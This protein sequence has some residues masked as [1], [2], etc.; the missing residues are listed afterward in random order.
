MLTLAFAAVVAALHA[1]GPKLRAVPGIAP[2]AGVS[3]AGGLAGAYVFIHVLPEL[4]RGNREV[5]AT[6]GHDLG[7]SAVVDVAVF[8]VALVGFSVF[9]LLQ[10]AAEQTNRERREP[11]GAV[12]VSHLVAFT[13]YNAVV[14]FTLPLR[15]QTSP[16]LAAAFCAILA[17]HLVS[18]DRLLREQFPQRFSVRA[19]PRMVLA[20][21]ALG[22]WLLAGV[23][24]ERTVTL[25]L[26]SA[27]LGGA[28]LLNVLDQELPARREVRIGWFLAGLVTT[29]SLLTA[30]AAA[31][32]RG[33]A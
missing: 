17:L 32:E 22:G 13:I 23:V 2:D 28:I 8:L 11:S 10:W 6:L 9:F 26:L 18:A 33:A 7:D 27:L 4:A 24:P 31:G 29:A 1:F 19:G 14:V 20:A 21:G 25:S 30:L 15:F 5:A 12:F 16:A 3:L